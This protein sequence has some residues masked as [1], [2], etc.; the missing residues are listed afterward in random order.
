[1]MNNINCDELSDEVFCELLKKWIQGFHGSVA[2]HSAEWLENRVKSYMKQEDLYVEKVNFILSLLPK[3]VKSG[4]DLG[5][6]A[7]GLSVAFARCGMDMIGIEPSTAGVEVSRLRA[8]RLGMD[9]VLFECGVGEQ[10]PF[11]DNSFDFIA[12]L[13]V[14]EHV[15]NVNN[16]L[17][18]CFRVL[19]P[20]GYAYFEVPNNIFPFEAHYKMIWLPM[21]PKRFAKSYVRMRGAYPEFLDTLH[22]MNRL[23]VNKVFSRAGFQNTRD[24]YGEFLFGKAVGARW[25]SGAGRING[26]RWMAPFL[27]LFCGSLPSALFLNRVV[28]V[29]AEKPV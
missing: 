4:L 3:D 6:S 14:L 2:P 25:S 7:G 20:G 13:A 8:K 21:F 1:M 29:T 10:L 28:C 23:I 17:S 22:Y 15:Q 26:W 12:S 9:N 19:R 5:S 27:R 11:A 16:V 24:V 18:E